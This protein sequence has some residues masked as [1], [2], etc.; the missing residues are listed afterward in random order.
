MPEQ[1]KAKTEIESFFWKGQKRYRCPLNWESGAKC[2]FDTNSLDELHK[3]MAK[4]NHQRLVVKDPN[5]P[6]Q[7]SALSHADEPPVLPVD[8]QFED[9]SY[10]DSDAPPHSAPHIDEV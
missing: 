2:H 1:N 4:G 6:I 8:P 3:H 10:S 5:A 9:L 7:V